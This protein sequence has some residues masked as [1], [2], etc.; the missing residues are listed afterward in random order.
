MEA[1]RLSRAASPREPGQIAVVC[2]LAA[3][4]AAAWAATWAAAGSGMAG[5]E[6]PAMRAG[7]LA[8]FIA[9]WV[10]M[11]A[12]MMFPSV[13]PL[14]LSY[15]RLMGARREHGLHTP[16]GATALLLVG[17]LVVWTSA[18]LLGYVALMEA[19]ALAPEALAWE[20]GGPY[21]AGVVIVAASAYQFTPL[22]DACLTRCRGPLSFFV[23]H[24]HEGRAG[25]I[26]MGALHGAYCV[27]C[28]WALM[29]ALFALGAMSVAWMALVAALIAA[30]KLLPWRGLATA[31]VSAV[32]LL[33][34][35][36]VV[37]A[38]ERVPGQG[39]S[40]AE[41]PVAGR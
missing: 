20:R 10:L 24:W 32:L 7:P 16:T 28:C 36:S 25:A 38:P 5:M 40:G 33:L 29:G 11:M 39:P 23:E 8:F 31:A 27:G 6:V 21:L 1:A 19:D 30:E 18:G 2:G 17:Y 14:V 34:G 41:M 12:A 37:I 15:R 13:S 26:R 35:L 22:R 3:L 4:A 9:I